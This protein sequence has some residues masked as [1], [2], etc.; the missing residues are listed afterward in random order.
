M[1]VGQTAG[2]D[3]RCRRS[4]SRLCVGVVVPLLTTALFVW[5]VLLVVCVVVFDVAPELLVV[6]LV[7]VSVWCGDE[8]LPPL[9]PFEWTM[10]PVITVL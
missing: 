4:K 6:L 3:V 5:A 9:E 10:L 2:A 1:E 7:E 8:V